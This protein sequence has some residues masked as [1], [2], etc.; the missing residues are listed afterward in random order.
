M[1]IKLD[2]RFRLTTH[3][4][5]SRD[6]KTVLVDE[7]GRGY[8]PREE[9]PP[10]N[11]LAVTIVGSH[12]DRL[13]DEALSSRGSGE[14]YGVAR[15]FVMRGNLFSPQVDSALQERERQRALF[16]AERRRISREAA[17]LGAAE[18]ARK[19]RIFNTIAKIVFSLVCIA[20][21]SLLLFT[22]VCST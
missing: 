22:R 17:E 6:G 12:L 19:D 4:E 18:K 14:D 11:E 20:L 9:V 5:R 7:Q 8:T 1:D 16:W 10:S 13:L 3:H 21:V 15:E 2:E